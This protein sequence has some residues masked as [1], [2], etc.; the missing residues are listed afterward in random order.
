MPYL[1]F[2]KAYVGNGNPADT[3]AGRLVGAYGRE[4]I[5]ELRTLDR[6][7]YTSLPEE[8]IQKRN[9]D[10]VLTKYIKKKKNEN[11]T[12]A[13]EELVQLVPQ[14]AVQLTADQPEKSSEDV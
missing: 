13:V 6:F 2:S 12:A 8:D 5:H 1:T 9:K 3:L 4:K 11:G 14:P 10:Q 7:Y